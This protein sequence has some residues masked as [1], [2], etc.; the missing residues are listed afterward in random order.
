MSFVGLPLYS[1]QNY[2]RYWLVM[3][4]T[5]TVTFGWINAWIYNHCCYNCFVCCPYI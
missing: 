3:A 1:L 2:G 5:L 4:G